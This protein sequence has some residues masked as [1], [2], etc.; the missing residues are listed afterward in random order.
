MTILQKLTIL[1]EH[2]YRITHVTIEKKEK[3]EYYRGKVG[4]IFKKVFGY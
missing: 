3:G 2:G 1:Y 4:T